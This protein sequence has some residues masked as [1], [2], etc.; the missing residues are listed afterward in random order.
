M[1]NSR[2]INALRPDVGSKLPCIH[3]VCRRQ[4]IQLKGYGTGPR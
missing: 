2:D 1:L 3:A 4:A